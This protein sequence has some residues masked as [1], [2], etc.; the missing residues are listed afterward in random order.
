MASTADG[1]LS[2]PV[3]ALVERAEGG[4]GPAR[5]ELFAALYA[6]LHSLARRE[7]ARGGGALSLSATTLLHEVYLNMSRHDDTRFPD[8]AR[9]LAYAARA[10]RGVLVDHARE[11]HALKRGGAFHIT[12]L[13][14]AAADAIAAETS[15]LP[16]D[17]A[18]KELEALEPALAQV[19][20]L[21]FFC[22]LSFAEIAALQQCSERTVQR[23][24]EKARLL[25]Y[26]ALR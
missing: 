15:L 26:R 25:L 16:L 24:W 10:M 14:T 21:K 6:R 12:A 20:D 4:D 2:A 1:P 8:E 22:G 9:F 23:Q 17:D 5:G 13:D 19:V 7:V 3:A 18:L 11:R